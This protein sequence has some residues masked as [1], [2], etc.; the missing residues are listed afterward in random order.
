VIQIVCFGSIAGAPDTRTAKEFSL[1]NESITLNDLQSI[2]HENH[3]QQLDTPEIEPAQY[4]S[5]RPG[6]DGQ[7]MPDRDDVSDSKTPLPYSRLTQRI[8]LIFSLL[9]NEI[10]AHLRSTC[11]SSVMV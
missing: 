11:L 5:N 7:S 10:Q 1:F 4:I 2:A 6:M 8:P 3:Y 9:S